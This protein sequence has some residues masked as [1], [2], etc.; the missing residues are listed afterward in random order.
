MHPIG[1][2]VIG[3]WIGVILGIVI[4]GLFRRENKDA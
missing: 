2:I 1:L 4:I 3:I